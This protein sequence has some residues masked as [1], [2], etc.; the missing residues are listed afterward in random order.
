MTETKKIDMKKLGR[1][2]RHLVV[3]MAYKSKTAHIG[4]A[5]SIADILVVL[6]FKVMNIDPKKPKDPKR[7]RFILSKGHGAASLY[8]TMALRGYFPLK[9]LEKYRVNKGRFAGHPCIDSAEGIE[10]SSGSL[11][12][13]LPIGTGMALSIKQNKQKSKV[14]V[15]LGDGECQEGSNWEAAMF[16][17]THKLNNL[18]A[19]VDENGWQGLG[20]T[21][22]IQARPLELIWKGFGWNV[23][24]C[25]GH[26]V[27][28]LT[29]AF[30]LTNKS[31]KPSVIIAKT[32]TGKNIP[33]IENTLRAHYHV[34]KDEEYADI[35]KK[36][37]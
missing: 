29:K 6:Y 21:K 26:D 16:A 32:L 9:E 13:G 10:V 28:S 30:S 31:L 12:H 36:L 14:Y 1:E 19:I 3:D 35:I 2:I 18:V 8:A 37:K 33:L 24:K 20:I 27:N 15:L 34:I 22:E 11:G 23:I 25:D 4:S 5:I 17:F 7:D